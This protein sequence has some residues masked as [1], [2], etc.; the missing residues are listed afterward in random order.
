MSDENAMQKAG[1]EF[2]RAE[3][4]AVAEAS[5]RMV[6]AHDR[7][8]WYALFA[9]DA[10]V[11]DPVGTPPC[12]KGR[13]SRGALGSKDELLAFYQ[14]FIAHNDIRF[15]VHQD[16]VVGLTV[17]R[18]VTI[19]ARMPTGFTSAVPAY[20]L[21]ELVAADGALKIT[22]L[23]AH[24]EASANSKQASSAG[25]RGTASMLYSLGCMLR[26]L[27]PAG[28]REYVRGTRTGVRRPGRQTVEALARA[29]EA[30]DRQALGALATT[31]ASLQLGARDG[32]PLKDVLDVVPGLGLRVWD[33]AAGGYTVSGRCE[34]TLDGRTH[35]GLAFFDFD[36]PTR[37]IHR[38]RILFDD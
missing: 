4:L 13:V 33:L 34:V 7:D 11:E 22:R 6:A 27:G 10:V 25:L 24:W 19:Y 9:D 23:A 18:D 2:D 5:P 38:A 35:R 36:R 28:T 31:R 29:I 26:Y 1:E 37:T 3:R 30:G 12:G 21:Y 15:E 8:G 17:A 14:A 32:L 16:I 20:L